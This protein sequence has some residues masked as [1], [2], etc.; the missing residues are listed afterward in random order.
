[1]N[2]I[3]LN[4]LS[5]EFRG[6]GVKALKINSEFKSQSVNIIIEPNGELPLHTTPVDVIFYVIKGTGLLEIGSEKKEVKEGTFIDSPANIP[7]GWSNPSQN[8]ILSVLVI[9]LYN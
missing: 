3:E 2:I 1:M 9:K 4:K 5:G 6:K 7:H 8:E